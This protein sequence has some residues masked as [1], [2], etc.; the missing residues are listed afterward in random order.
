MSDL[1]LFFNTLKPRVITPATI[2]HV[3]KMDN[4][5]LFL[6]KAK[7]ISFIIFSPCFII[8]GSYQKNKGMK[9]MFS[10]NKL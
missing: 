4:N 5:W 10:M 1:K 9:I 6:N 7:L 2:K 3:I 8:L